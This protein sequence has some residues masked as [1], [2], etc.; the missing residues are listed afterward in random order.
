MAVNRS[1]PTKTE[2]RLDAIEHAIAQ[3][4][5]A[6]RVGFGWVPDARGQATLAKVVADAQARHA[7][8]ERDDLETRPAAE[9]PERR[10]A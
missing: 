1:H 6:A 5:E 4:A 7:D 9:A 2:Q 10:A 8:R 3:L